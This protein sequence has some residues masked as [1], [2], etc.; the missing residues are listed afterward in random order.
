MPSTRALSRRRAAATSVLTIVVVMV[1]VLVLAVGVSVPETWWPHTGQAFA[2]DTRPT[3]QDPCAL[4]VDPAE[5]HCEHG[6]ATTHAANPS[7][8]RPDVAGAVWRLAAAGAGLAA[9]FVWRRP[10]A[11]SQRQR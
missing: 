9:L 2:T 7:A 10:S 1:G 8:G 11:A 3:G 6:T 5:D 4:I